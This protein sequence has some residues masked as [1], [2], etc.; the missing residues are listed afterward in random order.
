MIRLTITRLA[1]D[2]WVMQQLLFHFSTGLDCLIM[3][4]DTSVTSLTMHFSAKLTALIKTYVYEE[5]IHRELNLLV[6]SIWLPDVFNTTKTKWDRGNSA[7]VDFWCSYSFKRSRHRKENLSFADLVR[8]SVSTFKINTGNGTSSLVQLLFYVMDDR[9]ECTPIGHWWNM[10]TKYFHDI[11]CRECPM[12]ERRLVLHFTSSQTMF[13]L[14]RVCLT[15]EKYTTW[16][17]ITELL[18]RTKSCWSCFVFC[19]SFLDVHYQ[20]FNIFSNVFYLIEWTTIVS[21]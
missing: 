8:F 16:W 7:Y 4:R 3:D 6:C 9:W 18:I 12:T 11:H 1:R 15:D 10:I 20:W 17:V 19:S 5:Q 2:V 13:F 14:S 21:T